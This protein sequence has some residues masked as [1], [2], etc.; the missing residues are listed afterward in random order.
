M[1]DTNQ[2]APTKIQKL[3]HVPE[4]MAALETELTATLE[5]LSQLEQ[6]LEPALNPTYLTTETVKPEES[7]KRAPLAERVW[8]N[9]QT[10]QTLHAKLDIILMRAEL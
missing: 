9:V 10:V 6:K 8:M 1:S 3:P 2:P 5:A 4:A 7:A